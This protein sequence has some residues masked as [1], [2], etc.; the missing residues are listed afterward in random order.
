MN[1]HTIERLKAV[2]PLLRRR[3]EAL[4]ARLAEQ[5]IVVEVVQGFRTEREQ[6]ELYAQ[7]RTK[8]GKKV[9]NAKAWQSNHNYGL[10]VD[11]CPFE[12]GVPNW[13]AP[14]ATWKLI[15]LEAERQHLEWGGRWKSIEDLPHVQ[16]P[17]LSISQCYELSKG[18]SLQP[19][20]DAASRIAGVVFA[21][22]SPQVAPKAG[23][24]TL[25]APT[26]TT[27]KS[28]PVPPQIP[29]FPVIAPS[30]LSPRWVENV[31]PPAPSRA[32]ESLK[33]GNTLPVA[34]LSA[35]LAARDF[36]AANRVY[37]FAAL[38]II[39]LIVVWLEFRPRKRR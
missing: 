37:V 30:G 29:A 36:L 31:T 35:I 23:T 17:G 38:A 12:N 15:G 28:G 7:G 16:L 11:L 5:G 22:Q 24:A 33:Q 3:V 34:L 4:I 1:P 6:N 21:P 27:S 10:A 39:L 9:T 2:H 19:V 20:W 26:L 25:P 18:G 32:V 14:R 13:N 8:P